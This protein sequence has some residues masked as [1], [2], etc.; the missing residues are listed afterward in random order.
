MRGRPWRRLLPWGALSTAV[1]VTV[2]TSTVGGT[3]AAGA[4]GSTSTG[5]TLVVD[6]PSVPTD[7]NPHTVAGDTAE[8]TA[9]ANAVLPQCYQVAPGLSVTIDSHLL[10]SAEVVSVDPQT[11]VYQINPKAV[12]SDGTPIRADDFV[13]LW[14]KEVGAPTGGPDTGANASVASSIGYRDIASVTGSNGGTTVRVVFRTPYADWTDLF[15]DLIPP[16]VATVDGWSTGFDGAAPTPLVSG[17]PWEVTSWTPGQR[18]ELSP[19]PRWWGPKPSLGH[20]VLQATGSTT[21]MV[22]DLVGGSSQVIQPDSLSLGTLDAVS[23]DPSVR[24]SSALGTTMLQLV[25]DTRRAPLDQTVVRQGIAHLV[26]RAQI[27][28]RLVQPLQPLSW[29]DGDFLAPNVKRGYVDDGSAYLDADP[30]TADKLLASA[31]ITP[32]VWDTLTNPDGTPLT[33]TLTWAADDPWSALVG[34][35]VAA[36]LEAGGIDVDSL[37]VDTDSLAGT[38][39][40]GGDWDLALM[41]IPASPWLS[42][43]A[44]AY[45][46][47]VGALGVDGTQD[48]SGFDDPA[49]DNLLAEASAQLA[50]DQSGRLYRQADQLLWTDLPALPLFAEPTVT[51]WSAEV[52]GVDPDDGAAG[53]LWGAQNLTVATTDSH[54][55][56]GGDHR[57]LR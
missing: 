41:P 35:Q 30:A 17:G 9:V 26:D 53:V 29:V 24:S 20:I 57:G 47:G 46:T 19:N 44:P 5:A 32:N 22:D 39:A 48:W 25:F 14:H 4:T 38:L 13:Y 23:S 10:D 27:A 52:S 36:D 49:L 15:D 18:L 21:A 6:V 2:V 28:S 12:W 1:V 3:A 33:L 45:S 42:E 43:L 16:Q 7:L 40:P 11:V 56:R 31:G 55:Q 50:A 37:P 54:Q 34:P 8:T 51:A